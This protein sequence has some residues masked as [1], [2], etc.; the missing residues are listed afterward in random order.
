MNQARVLYIHMTGVT[1]EIIKN[2]VLAGVRA[3]ICDDRDYDEVGQNQAI[4]SIF[5]PPQ[6]RNGEEAPAGK[7]LKR[8]VAD[9]VQSAIEELNPLL[10]SCEIVSKRV[11]DLTSVDLEPFSIVVA[12][13]LSISDAIHVSNLLKN[14]TSVRKA[15]YLVD[16]F[17]WYGSAVIDLG[18][19]SYFYRPEKGKEL[20]EPVE[21]TGPYK[22]FRDIILTSK[23]QDAV[24]RFYKP[25]PPLPWLFH[26]LILQYMEHL[27]ETRARVST[28]EHFAEVIHQWLQRDSPQ[29]LQ[30][31]ELFAE[32]KETPQQRLLGRVLSATDSSVFP[33]IASQLVPVC[34][35]MGGLLGNEIIKFI[36]GN[37]EPA[38]NT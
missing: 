19:P 38:N 2:L 30:Q 23:L 22:S 31:L 1:S 34:S 14:G 35:V 33:I 25:T 3:G 24:S 21:L 12:S 9:V 5:F 4:P 27:R 8:S 7:R 11:N 13:Q 18:G 10:G 37:G 20:L 26:R 29:L 32:S 6:P 36:S 15:F 17:G 16:T 28:V